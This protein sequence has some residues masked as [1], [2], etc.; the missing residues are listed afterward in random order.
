[1]DFVLNVVCCGKF[2]SPSIAA[3]FLGGSLQESE[4]EISDLESVLS[5][6]L[7][8]LIGHTFGG[9]QPGSVGG[10]PK[11]S[12][13]GTPGSKS[14]SEFATVARDATVA[15]IEVLSISSESSLPS[16]SSILAGSG[17]ASSDAESK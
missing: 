7:A 6:F 1:M 17:D 5:A 11:G 14:G 2:L 10:M 13:G 15:E 3:F 16:C 4:D 8:F 12:K 9:M